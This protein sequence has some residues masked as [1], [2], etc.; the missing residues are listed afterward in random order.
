MPMRNDFFARAGPVVAR[1]GFARRARPQGNAHRDRGHRL[2]ASC[3]RVGLPG[4]PRGIHAADEKT[5]SMAVCMNESYIVSHATL[6]CQHP[7]D[8]RWLEPQFGAADASNNAKATWNNHRPGITDC[9][10]GQGPYRVFDIRPGV[11]SRQPS[12][13]RTICSQ[14]LQ[15]LAKNGTVLP[16][17][18]L[19]TRAS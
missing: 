5:R 7:S 18:P 14:S 13:V 15:F 4:H 8:D 6:P 19:P 12:G 17:P 1:S 3:P 11:Y 16:Y 9:R 2:L 10:D